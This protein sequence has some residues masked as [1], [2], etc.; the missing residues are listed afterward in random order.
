MNDSYVNMFRAIEETK[1]PDFHFQPEF[2]KPKKKVAKCKEFPIP[3]KEEL[4]A[5]V[6]RNNPACPFYGRVGQD[7]VIEQL[8]AVLVEAWRNKYHIVKNGSALMFTGPAST[9]KT[10]FIEALFGKK[11]LDLPFVM[12]D[13]KN[14][15]GTNVIFDLMQSTTEENGFPMT[16]IGVNG[17][18]EIYKAPPMGFAIDELHGLSSSV[19]DALLKAFEANDKMLMTKDAIVDCRN[20]LWVGATTERGTILARHEPFDSRFEKVEFHSYTL[21]QVSRILKL[22]FSWPDDVCRATAIR[23]G[24]IVREALAIGYKAKRQLSLMELRSDEEIAMIE[25]ID[26]VGEQLGIDQWGM[27]QKQIDVL[28]ALYRKYPKG[29]TYGQ[30]TKVINQGVDELK[31]AVLPA[32]M[33][34]TDDNPAK[35]VWSGKTTI[36]E[37]GIEELKKRSLIKDDSVS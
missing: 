25:A 7:T 5:R 31:N 17:G 36:T 14:I 34:E 12:T 16:P 28:M 26:R 20:V 32:L 24:R 10:T 6:N 37:T 19:M 11:G 2:S 30:L 22:A 21:E 9:G 29:M 27:S 15:K 3:S 33:L 35:V 13:A 23:G 18:R 8:L 4:L 1:H